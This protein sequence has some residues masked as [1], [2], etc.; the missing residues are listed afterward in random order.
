MLVMRCLSVMLLTATAVT[1]VQELN[2]VACLAGYFLD[3]QTKTCRH[4]PANLS[5]FVNANATLATDCLCEAGLFNGTARCE[6]CV[7]GT[8]KATLK[9]ATCTQCMPHANTLSEASVDPVDCLC[10]MGYTVQ[11]AVSPDTETCVSC[12][13]GTFKGWLG[14]EIC[15]TC[16]GNS[17]CAKTSILPTPCPPHS[18][19]VPGSS[20]VYDCAC[21]PG[22]RHEYTHS[23]PPSLQCGPCEAGTYTVV[24]NTLART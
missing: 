12:A 14:D 20:S 17:Y 5:T 7:F 6:P 18:V 22:F 15:T 11:V 9:N 1:A 19:S 24:C 4:C 23:E 2:C 16:H 8:F 3:Y 13:P 10:D 21:K